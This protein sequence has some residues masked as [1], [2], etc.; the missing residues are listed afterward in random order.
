MLSESKEIVSV[1]ESLSELCF[2]DLLRWSLPLVY[3]GGKV[4]VQG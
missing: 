3:A 2:E 4:P 1:F